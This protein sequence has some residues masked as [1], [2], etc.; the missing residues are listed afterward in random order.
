MERLI[1]DAGFLPARRT[2]DYR[3][4]PVDAAAEAGISA[5]AA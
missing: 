1:R 5:A 3:L 4:M 2:Q